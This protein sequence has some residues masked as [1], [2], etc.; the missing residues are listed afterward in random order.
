MI[1][2]IVESIEIIVWHGQR[3]IARVPIKAFI[4]NPASGGTKS[5]KWQIKSGGNTKP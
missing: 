4:P 1:D 3:F 2:G 5:S